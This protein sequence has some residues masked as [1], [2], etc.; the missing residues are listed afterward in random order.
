MSTGASNA[1]AAAAE[2]SASGTIQEG[3]HPQLP[4]ETLLAQ[5]H[6]VG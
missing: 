6:P 3:T 5:L 1:E 2:V 4:P